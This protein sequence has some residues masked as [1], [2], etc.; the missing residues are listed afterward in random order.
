MVVED[1]HKQPTLVEIEGEEEPTELPEKIGEYKVESMLSKGGMSV[2]Y[3]G[4]HPELKEPITLKV[5]SKKYVSH[6]EMVARF[7]QEAKIIELT[8]HPNIVKIYGHGTW[9]GGVYIAMEFIQGLSLR[10]MIMQEATS[11][12]RSL[13]FVMQIAQALTHLHVHGIIHRDLKPE[14][15]LL[16]VQGG[17][18]VIDFGISQLYSQIDESSSLMMGTPVYMSPEQKADPLNVGFASD[19]YSLGILTYE[20]VL[21]RLSHGQVHLSLLPKGLQKI[22][23]KTLMPNPKDRYE[24]IVDFIKDLSLYMGSEQLKQDM[25]GVDYLGELNESLKNSQLA[26][27]PPVMPRWPFGDIY[28][29]SNSNSAISSLYYDFFDREAGRFQIVFGESFETGVEGLI[30]IAMLK[31]MVNASIEMIREP[32]EL[33]TFLNREIIRKMRDTSFSFSFLTLDLSEEIFS[34]ISCGYAPLWHLTK[35]GKNAK[36]LIANNLA[37]G[38]EPDFEVVSI[39]ANWNIGDTLIWHSYQAG[40]LPN[41]QKQEEVEKDFTEALQE[42]SLLSA[43]SQVET[44][45][46]KVTQ[47]KGEKFLARPVTIFS[48][49]R[50]S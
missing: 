18:K 33:I 45:F 14:N 2:L 43:K 3:L 40:A 21:G 36:R 9:E 27:L 12:R 13:Q 29:A 20:L 11:L 8:D 44:I 4:T 16:T 38:L 50:T 34:Y 17:I 49:V 15:I 7:M 1:F 22:V 35:G 23:A 31:G 5:L 46:R 30:A 41:N 47:Q 19:I 6:P 32:K 39:S 42:V 28:L 10:Q 26:L 48:V 24:D 37:L 25:R